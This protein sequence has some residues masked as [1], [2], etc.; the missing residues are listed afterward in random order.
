[1]AA[2]KYIE[3]QRARHTEK[4]PSVGHVGEDRWTSL[5]ADV[6]VML[7]HFW[8]CTNSSCKRNQKSPL[9][10]LWDLAFVLV[11]IS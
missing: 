5:G 2:C 11:T 4:G 1:M 9:G 6:I 8:N 7:S 10:E 3:V